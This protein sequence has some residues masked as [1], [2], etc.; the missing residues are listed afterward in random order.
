MIFYWK[1]TKISQKL[2][3]FEKMCS[4]PGDFWWKK[5]WE[6]LLAELRFP[7]YF[8]AIKSI[9]F[10]DYKQKETFCAFKKTHKILKI[11]L[12]LD[13]PSC[14]SKLFPHYKTEKFN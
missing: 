14:V 11:S 3:N 8:L 13:I 6:K 7:G 4:R 9:E 10:A 2:W 12:A 5:G 1:F